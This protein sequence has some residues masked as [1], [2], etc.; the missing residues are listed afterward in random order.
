[1]KVKIINHTPGTYL[2]SYQITI[3]DGISI[4]RW[5]YMVLSDVDS[6]S[7]L[8]RRGWRPNKFRK[9]C[10]SWQVLEEYTLPGVIPMDLEDPT[11]TIITFK[12]LIML[13]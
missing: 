13:Q 3:D 9:R 10:T 4:Q 11:K 5:G 1:M 7:T 8:L 6:C 12:K 2:N